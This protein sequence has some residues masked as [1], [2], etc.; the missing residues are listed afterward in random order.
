MGAVL[1]S[2]DNRA[3]AV[4]SQRA[5]CYAPGGQGPFLD[6]TEHQPAPKYTNSAVKWPPLE[7]PSGFHISYLP[8]WDSILP[9]A[10]NVQI[11]AEHF[12]F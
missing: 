1:K 7:E 6:E 11:D 12:Y 8:V 4:K 10:L 9:L 5:A 2:S 3:G